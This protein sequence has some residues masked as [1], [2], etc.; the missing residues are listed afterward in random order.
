MSMTDKK[1]LDL[2]HQRVYKKSKLFDT[3]TKNYIRFILQHVLYNKIKKVYI[4]TPENKIIYV[5]GK[6]KVVIVKNTI[7]NTTYAESL[8]QS[9]NVV[10]FDEHKFNEAIKYVFCDAEIRELKIKYLINV[11]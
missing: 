5:K 8:L 7:M 10:G 3:D 6:K 4:R 11:K 2:L 9:V 1:D